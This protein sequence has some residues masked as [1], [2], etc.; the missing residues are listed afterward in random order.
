MLFLVLLLSIDHRPG[1]AGPRC[2]SLK[3]EISVFGEINILNLCI[4]LS[5]YSPPKLVPL[6]GARGLRSVPEA[7]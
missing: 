1:I 7:R 3:C 4:H 5:I 6:R 2:F